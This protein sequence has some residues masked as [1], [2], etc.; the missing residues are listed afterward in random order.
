[1]AFDIIGSTLGQG[2]QMLGGH[3]ADDRR[4]ERE[5]WAME[6]NTNNAREFAQHG[7]RWRVADATAAGLHPLYALSGNTAAAPAQSV[8][9]GGFGLGEA[10]AQMGQDVSRAARAGSSRK[11]VAM[12]DAISAATLAEIEARTRMHDAHTHSIYNEVARRGQAA[13]VAKP[14][15]DSETIKVT[16]GAH[17]GGGLRTGHIEAKAAEQRSVNPQFPGRAASVNPFFDEHRYNDSGDSLLLPSKDLGEILESA[18]FPVRWAIWAEAV[19][20]NW[21]HI[22]KDEAQQ[23][24][25]KAQRNFYPDDQR[26]DWSWV[27]GTASDF[28]KRALGFD[29][30]PRRPNRLK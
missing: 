1:M 26:Q 2:L 9:G 6:Q 22:A 13:G 28:Y 14:L 19:R 11:E 18:P 15:P 4:E 25:K 10:M 3:I 27:W 17:L 30:K 5:R 21:D 16:P 23:R 20:R 12:Q 24:P 8:S 7:I 29:G